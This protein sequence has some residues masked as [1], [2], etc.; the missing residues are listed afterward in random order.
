MSITPCVCVFV[1]ICVSVCLKMTDGKDPVKYMHLPSTKSTIL[2]VNSLGI[3]L[4]KQP[5]R[6]IVHSN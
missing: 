3:D 6:V 5:Q 1:S 4:G 2:G